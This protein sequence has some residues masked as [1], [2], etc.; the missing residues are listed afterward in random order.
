MI[1]N[2]GGKC[3]ICGNERENRNLFA[4][5]M[6]FGKR[7]VFEYLECTNCGCIQLVD[8]PNDWADY[9][10]EDYYSFQLLPQNWPGC[11]ENW[12][13]DRWK[14]VI[15]SKML[16]T[17]LSGIPGSTFF[18]RYLRFGKEM[19]ALVRIHLKSNDVILDVGCGSGWLLYTLRELGYKNVLGV[20]PYL[21]CTIEYDNG[22]IV[23]KTSLQN[24]HAQQCDLVMFHH[25]FEHSLCPRDDLAAAFR[26]LRKGGV[27][28]IRIPVASS[29]AWRHYQ[30]NWVQ[31]DAPRHI[32]LHTLKS[33]EFMAK[34]IG[35]CLDEVV[36]D[37]SAFQIWGSEQYVNNISLKESQFQPVL[38]N[39]QDLEE[40]QQRAEQ[41]N[42]EGLG[43]Q[44]VF[45][46]IKR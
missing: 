28:L 13:K 42:S 7:D 41:L 45:Y 23:R 3:R 1:S 5:E 34:E 29:W 30:T 44:A 31:F 40:F 17:V 4:K 15:K 21:K 2:I 10:P 33:I 16:K 36:Y 46:L 20:D 38:F 39:K 35:F 24:W 32:H 22:L 9:Y 18:R 43:D 12:S 26:L 25:S 19:S 37:S 8:I 27:C 6:M 11:P 14:V